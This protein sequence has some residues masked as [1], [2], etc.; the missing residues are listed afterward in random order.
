MLSAL[1]LRFQLAGRLS[2]ASA[3][4]NNTF[5]M[6]ASR[7]ASDIRDEPVTQPLCATSAHRDR[8]SVTA[9]LEESRIRANT[10]TSA[11]AE[12]VFPMK[13]AQLMSMLALTTALTIAPCYAVEIRNFRSGLL[14]D[15]NEESTIGD[16]PIR[17]ICLEAE[18]I[19]ITG[20]GQ[21]TY[22]GR[23]EKCTWYGYEFDYSNAR[24]EDE[25]TCVSTSSVPVNMGTPKGVDAEGVTVYEYSYTLPRGNGHH[26]NPQYSVS[27]ASP[28]QQSVH[29][30]TVCSVDGKEL[31]R[32]RFTTIHPALTEDTVRETL[33][34]HLRRAEKAQS[35]KD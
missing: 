2:A 30:E 33:N 22:D 6:P 15:I 34:R 10:A 35:K 17:W 21:C 31:Y 27:A 24:E 23:Q 18:I 8:L 20:Q 12:L 28:E 11:S 13:S 19:Y 29:D 32:Y 7:P 16:V 14:C 3:G 25:I 26:F 9:V 5:P 1:G 4:G